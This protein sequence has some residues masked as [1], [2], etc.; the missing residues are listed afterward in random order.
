MFYFWLKYRKVDVVFLTLKCHTSWQ[1]E[2]LDTANK[3]RC[4]IKWGNAEF[5]I[6]G[7]ADPELNKKI[8]DLYDIFKQ[9]IS[10]ASIPTEGEGALP[11][12]RAGHRGGG[13]KPAFIKNAILNIIQK[14]P[15]WFVEKSPEDVMEKL[16]TE[17]GV[18]GANVS[19]VGVALI[20]LFADGH[21][22]RKESEGKYLYSITAL[23]T[24]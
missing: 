15:S 9:A 24:T 13:K 11:A 8:N 19:P 4:R 18:P 7:A 6:E 1:G 10:S 16:K 14:E 3:I 22:T 20:R 17:Y 2:N 23:Q 21:L 12:T 5:E